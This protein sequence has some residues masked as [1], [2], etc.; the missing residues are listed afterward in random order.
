MLVSGL[1]VGSRTI[2]L[3]EWDG[4]QVVR[5]EVVFT[6][7]S[8]LENSQKLTRG[9]HYDRMIATGYGRHFIT[10]HSLADGV[11]TE[12]KAYALGA[13]QLFPDA[14]T[15][16][17]IGGQDSKVILM[18]GNGNVIKF[19]MNDRCAA[20]TGRFLEN[21]ASALGLSVAELG[22]HA[23]RAEKSIPLSSMCTVF[24]ESEVVSLIGQGADSHCVALGIHEAIVNRINAVV[25]RVGIN[26]S[27]VFAGGVAYNP[28]M[29][30]LLA[31]KLCPEI[32]VPSDPQTVGALGA[33]IQAQNDLQKGQAS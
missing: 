22:V 23:L 2:A 27:F 1:D 13:K 21:M 8:P 11:I 16:L 26:P 4:V 24:A 31:E 10:E 25:Q 12:I 33:A 6:G 3:V 32:N 30:K 17:D 7:T 18:S 29:R 5:E 20:G 9:R 19:E 28:C 15:V 14:H